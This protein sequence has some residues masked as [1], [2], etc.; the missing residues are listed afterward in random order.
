MKQLTDRGVRRFRRTIRTYFRDHGRDFPWRRTRDPYR[1]LVSEVMLQ[2]T[3][4]DRVLKKYLEK[5]GLI[6]RVS[7]RRSIQ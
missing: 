3:Q 2:Q 7:Q 1:I 6:K 4:T 5:D